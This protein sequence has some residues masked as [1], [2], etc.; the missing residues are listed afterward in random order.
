MENKKWM[1]YGS[2]ERNVSGDKDHLKFAYRGMG[3]TRPKI[4]ISITLIDPE[5]DTRY[6][7]NV[8]GEMIPVIARERG[9]KNYGNEVE[10]AEG[11]FF[12]SEES[13]KSK[14]EEILT[15]IL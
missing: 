11:I 8:S 14:I 7:L 10:E 15:K 1:R 13:N 4:P 9:Q 6:E 5:G 3:I 12:F 2:R